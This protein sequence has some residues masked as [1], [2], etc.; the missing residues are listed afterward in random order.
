MEIA[1]DADLASA[2][3]RAGV[4]RQQ[5]RKVSYAFPI[6]IIAVSAVEPNGTLSEYFFR[7]ELSGFPGTAPSVHIWNCETDTLLAA[8][9]RP[10]GS[11][12]LVE[13]FKAWPETS[14]YRP[15]ERKSGAHGNWTQN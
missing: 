2:R 11:A 13:A 10:Q 4:L 12:R 1:V 8:D 3:F 5:W 7:F 14:V 6:L 9:R 15:W